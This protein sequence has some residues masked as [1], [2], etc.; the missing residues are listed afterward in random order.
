M[1]WEVRILGTG[2]I[3]WR[4]VV[5]TQLF[6]TVWRGWA[7]LGL[8]QPPPNAGLLQPCQCLKRHAGFGARARWAH[9]GAEAT[10]RVH[11]GQWCSCRLAS[12][13]VVKVEEN[14]QAFGMRK[15]TVGWAA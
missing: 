1:G 9:H 14:G 7:G 8:A 3:A 11:L 4:L 5:E 10:S 13:W 15:R 2:H 6:E 12:R